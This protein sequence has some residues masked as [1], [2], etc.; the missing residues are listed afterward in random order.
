[1]YRTYTTQDYLASRIESFL[2]GFSEHLATMEQ[3]V[4]DSHVAS[5]VARYRESDKNIGEEYSRHASEITRR[6]KLGGYRW[7][8][9]EEAAQAIESLRIEDVK[10]FFE[11]E[12]GVARRAGLSVRVT[13]PK[14]V[15]VEPAESATATTTSGDDTAG[16]VQQQEKEEAPATGEMAGTAPTTAA[17]EP[18]LIDGLSEGVCSCGDVSCAAEGTSTARQP[19]KP[20]LDLGQMSKLRPPPPS[21]PPPPPAEDGAQPQLEEACALPEGVAVKEIDI[22]NASFEHFKASRPLYPEMVPW[23]E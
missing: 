21:A 4:F 20:V 16:T 13:G 11:D 19:F 22:S 8:R 3:E 9:A 1:M 5:L 15:A 18:D 23:S 17:Q 12:L 6:G 7:Q 14:G 2:A 10:A